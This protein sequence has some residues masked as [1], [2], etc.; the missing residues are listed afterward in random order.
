MLRF[1]VPLLAI[2]GGC[3]TTQLDLPPAHPARPDSPVVAQTPVARVLAP[4][5][6]VAE[7]AG[8]TPEIA[9]PATPQKPA[10]D[11]EPSGHGHHHAGG[12]SP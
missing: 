11:P 3:A 8:D 2:L 5:F 1:V 10:G 4:D 12:K 7:A 9:Q 6:T